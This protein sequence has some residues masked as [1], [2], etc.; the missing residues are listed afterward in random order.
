MFFF[1]SASALN[2]AK[3]L[4]MSTS[5]RSIPSSFKR[6][7]NAWRPGVLAENQPV[8]GQPDRF[9]SHDLVGCLVLEHA[10]LMD[11]R[12]VRKGIV[13]DDRLVDRDRNAGDLRQQAAGRVDLL[14]DDVAR[15]RRR[16][17]RARVL[18]AITTSSS[19]VLPARS[20][21]PLI[22]HST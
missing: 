5:S 9:R 22:V 17:R 10:V 19:E 18:I 11:A 16:T 7:A 12:L 4:F 8:A 14:G 13:A 2:R 6:S 20:P 1:L 3:A 21:M 15:R